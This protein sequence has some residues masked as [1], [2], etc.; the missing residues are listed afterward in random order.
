MTLGAAADRRFA[1]L[2]GLAEVPVDRDMRGDGLG[3]QIARKLRDVK[4]RIKRHECT[5][6]I[7]QRSV[8]DLPDHAQR[9]S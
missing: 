8:R 1:S 9:I 3:S 5:R 2:A 4:V 6:G 7:V